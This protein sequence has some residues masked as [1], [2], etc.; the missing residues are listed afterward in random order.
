MRIVSGFILR[1]IIGEN[2]A[3]PSG[4]SARRL[5]GLVALNG[6]GKFLFELLQSEQT[7]KSLIRALQEEYEVDAATAAADVTDFL[8]MLRENDL[9]ES[10]TVA[11]S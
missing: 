3:I 9:L 10:E 6:S 8:N 2:V 1:Q 4:D 7:E 11:H 5:S